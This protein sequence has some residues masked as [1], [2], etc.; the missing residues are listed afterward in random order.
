[1]RWIIR[2]N[3][4]NPASLNKRSRD[5]RDRT[6]NHRLSAGKIIEYFDRRRLA[7]VATEGSNTE[8]HGADPRGHLL[9]GYPA[10]PGDIRIQRKAIR[11]CFQFQRGLA[12]TDQE[13]MYGWHRTSDDGHRL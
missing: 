2:C 4:G 12:V 10:S 11:L 8:R 5:R 3:E 6:G 13:Q 7:P 9:I 1:C